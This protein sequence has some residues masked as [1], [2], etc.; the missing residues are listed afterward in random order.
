MDIVTATHLLAGSTTPTSPGRIGYLIFAIAGGIGF[1]GYGLIKKDRSLSNF[2]KNFAW[3]AVGMLLVTFVL[4][5]FFH[6][7]PPWIDS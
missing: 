2:V 4:S 3:G 6:V 7:R 5:Y 1:T